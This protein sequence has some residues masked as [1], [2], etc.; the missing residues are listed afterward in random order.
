MDV[1]GDKYITKEEYRNFMKK[2]GLDGAIADRL[3][4]A[5]RKQMFKVI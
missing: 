2:L 3:F 1:N 5:E 4:N